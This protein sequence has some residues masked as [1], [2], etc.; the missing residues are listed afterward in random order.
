MPSIHIASRDDEMVRLGAILAVAA[1]AYW[2]AVLLRYALIPTYF[3][4]AEVD[5]ALL[6]WRLV[7]GEALYAA[8]D[9]AS[10][11]LTAYGPFL[12]LA[13][14]FFPALLGGSIMSGKLAG[15]LAAFFSV[16]IF[17]WDA[18]RRRGAGAALYGALLFILMLALSI[19]QSFWT[20]AEPPLILLVT[21]AVVALPRIREGGTPWRAAI[22]VG[23]LGGLAVATKIHGF[24]YFA[25]LALVGFWPWRGKVWPVMAL[26]G[27]VGALSLF[28]LPGVS[29]ST[30]I[31]G[32][33]GVVKSRG[34]EPRLLTIT[35]KYCL[36]FLV[37]LWALLLARILRKPLPKEKEAFIL[38]LALAVVLN[39]YPSSAPGAGWYHMLPFIPV[40]IYALLDG[41]DGLEGRSKQ[42]FAFLTVVAAIILSVPAQKRLWRTYNGLEQQAGAAEEVKTALGRYPGISMGMGIGSDNAV[43][44]RTSFVRPLLAYVGNRYFISPVMTMEMEYAGVPLSPA[45]LAHVKNCETKIWLIP[46]G[47]L[48]FFMTNYFTGRPVFPRDFTAMFTETYAPVERIGRFDVWRCR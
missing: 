8:P 38:V 24:I 47:E 16:V 45:K 28:L 3:D 13:N 48:P 44:Y 19:P 39:I 9:S 6:S 27:A 33:A 4:H 25:P 7:T 43:T 5:V 31:A 26:A 17:A 42:G 46:A 2:G 36:L 12:Y 32:L 20:R 15:M 37:P 21:L 14:A 1:L 35:L 30:F 40:I 41:L 29:L 10:Y 22:I 11:I 23:L 34:I 18:W